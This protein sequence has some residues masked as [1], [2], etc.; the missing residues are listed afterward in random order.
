M[1]QPLQFGKYLLLERIAVGGM[2]EVFVAKA[3]GVE[4]FERLLAIKKILPTMGEDNEFN[5]MF[6]D[7]ARIAV[8]LA[9]ANIVQ[10][11]ELG[12]VDDNLFIA[13]EYI[14][15]RDVRQ[16][17]ERFRKRG[18]PMPIPQACTIVAKVCE[19]LDY[20][21][22]KRDA[23]GTP[24]G[25][26]HRDVSPQNVLVSFEGDVKLIDFG[27]AK[28]ES[29]LQ[30]TQAGILKGKFSYMSPEQVRGQAI[31]HRSDIFAVGVLLWELLCGEKLF[32][33]DS[34]FAVLEKVRTGQVPLP[35]KINPEIPE[36]LERVMMKALATEVRDRY[37]WA[38]EL[39]DALVR[40]TLIGDVVYGSRQ[41]SE[42]MR[43]EFHA[44]FDKEQK[45]LRGWLGITDA[46]V[47]VT[48]SD[49]LRR[50]PLPR[51]PAEGPATLP[52]I[53]QRQPA[54]VPPPA[55]AVA[56]AQP[57]IQP[58]T[59]TGVRHRVA[60]SK[61]ATPPPGEL[62][63]V[64]PANKP[65]P[66]PSED[67]SHE[68]PT[69][70]MDG[71][72]LA[73]AEKALAARRADEA[74]QKVR[75]FGD[76]DNEATVREDGPSAVDARRGRT[77]E[78]PPPRLSFTLGPDE[79][80]PA[81]N[82]SVQSY[83]NAQTGAPK[84][85]TLKD[86][87]AAP[88]LP[89]SLDPSLLM[90]ERASAP[91]SPR[92]QTMPP[93]PPPVSAPPPPQ[94][95]LPPVTEGFDVS[96]DRTVAPRAQRTG[97]F[98]KPLRETQAEPKSNAVRNVAIAL[99]VVIAAA[100]AAWA[101]WPAD[102]A[103]PGRL[104]FALS[105]SVPAELLLDGKPAGSIPPF[106]RQ[107]VA[108]GPHHVEIRASG[109]KPFTADVNVSSA[110]KPVE[111][112]VE[113]VSEAPPAAPEP[114]APAPAPVVAPEVVP[115][116]P[117]K[118]RWLTGKH[119]DADGKQTGAEANGGQ[120][121]SAPPLDAA[122]A[123]APR[124]SESAHRD[125]GARPV[126]RPASPDDG[127]VLHVTT[128]P[129]GASVEIDGQAVGKTPLALPGLDPLEVHVIKVALEGYASERRAAK[130][131]EGRFTTIALSLQPLGGGSRA[132]AAPAVMSPGSSGGSTSSAVSPAPA[133][134]DP[135]PSAVTMGYLI[136]ATTPVAKVYV[137][138]R[139]TGRWTPVFPKYPI[140]IAPG[141][142]TITFETTAGH[143]Y[144]APVTIEAGKTSKLTKVDL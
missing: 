49:P 109:Y 118:P 120:A 140:S 124:R 52:P 91:M 98:S 136:A 144:D 25:I 119:D 8:Q 134:A 127:S 13:M 59:P 45:R 108:R 2:A 65:P 78:P 19:A 16:L 70:K 28:A 131:D 137:D 121:P 5:T 42:W 21:H 104:V 41:L 62:R 67:S 86:R 81:D 31:D 30:R 129:E 10:V 69:M 82:G 57:I 125:E 85:I 73:A 64:V 112:Q 20:A 123:R 88:R 135:A 97:A 56:P 63:A 76:D 122:P 33:G 39:H 103:A 92:A 114:A 83:L 4:G 111:V 54:T 46:E 107:D 96:E 38:S 139:D 99:V 101:F 77:G 110:S 90:G 6:V 34:D 141:P 7:E 27:I 128:T 115:R 12:K 60:P 48:P 58:P 93:P 117:S 132:P 55:Q 87:P 105:P 72:A 116:E 17:L 11:L 106:T 47:E 29:R 126:A 143:R 9:H 50:R 138:G 32:T 95:E 22:R 102:V 68:M 36:A 3:F 18:R 113:L 66:P 75:S 24:L 1:L 74:A 89:S 44:E 130:A 37:Q 35:R 79:K 94:I 40:F 84:P 80:T 51:L 100:G 14:S 61:T 26:V 53:A 71:N 15:G 133:I 142:H 43:D 23:R